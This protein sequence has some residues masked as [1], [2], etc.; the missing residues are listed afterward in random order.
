[1]RDPTSVK[2]LSAV[3]LVYKIN[4]IV[5]TH[6]QVKYKWSVS[7]TLMKA[8][9]A[10]KFIDKM[11]STRC[12]MAPI[13]LNF[14]RLLPKSLFISSALD[15]QIAEHVFYDLTMDGGRLEDHEVKS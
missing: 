14:H 5:V 4:T 15:R 8:F 7:I 11:P 3:L 6:C 2:L 12:R 9:Y 1:M 13:R 10:W